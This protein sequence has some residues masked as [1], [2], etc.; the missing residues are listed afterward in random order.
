MKKMNSKYDDDKI[1]K[2]IQID[3]IKMFL[4][5]SLIELNLNQVT[6]Y[7]LFKE[8]KNFN[9]LKEIISYIKNVEDNM[10]ITNN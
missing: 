5:P 1:N 6:I 4:D 7:S 3:N 9:V 8:L 10:K 2:L